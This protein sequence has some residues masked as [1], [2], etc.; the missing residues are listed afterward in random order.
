VRSSHRASITWGVASHV[1]CVI[2]N[3]SAKGA[4]LELPLASSVPDRFD[5]IVDGEETALPCQVKWR[6]G[7]MIGVEFERRGAKRLAAAESATPRR[8]NAGR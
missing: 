3:F 8:S 1:N 2:H 5:L 4:R 6:D 7:Q